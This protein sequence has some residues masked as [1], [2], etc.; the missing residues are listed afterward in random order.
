[1]DA[2]SFET[3][4]IKDRIA[5]C[6]DTEELRQL[7]EDYLE[8]TDYFYSENI[9]FYINSELFS[10]AAKVWEADGRTGY[11]E[12]VYALVPEHYRRESVEDYLNQYLEER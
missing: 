10:L 11:A 9:G 7:L 12:K 1:M 5:R 2:N 3:I 4:Y 8:R 6:E